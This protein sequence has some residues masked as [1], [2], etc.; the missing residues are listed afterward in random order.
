MK[1]YDINIDYFGD[2]NQCQQLFSLYRKDP[3]TSLSL[4][5]LNQELKITKLNFYIKIEFEKKDLG[6]K[7]V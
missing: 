5:F 4:S 2:I 1:A 3:V 7:I 6:I